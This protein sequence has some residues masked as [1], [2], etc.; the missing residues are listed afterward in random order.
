MGEIVIG[1]GGGVPS[2]MARKFHKNELNK[3]S[4]SINVNKLGLSTVNYMYIPFIR[5]FFF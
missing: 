4:Q 5:V 2:S 3:V 1:G